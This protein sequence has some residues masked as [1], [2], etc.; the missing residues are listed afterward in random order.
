MK[1]VLAVCAITVT[2]TPFS[3]AFAPL[4]GGGQRRGDVVAMLQAAK[5]GIFYGTSTGSTETVAE[6][7]AAELE[8][9]AEGPFDVDALEGDIPDIIAKYDAIIAGTP[10]WNTG[11]DTERSG[12][13]WDEIYSTIQEVQI[14]GNK[15]A[16]IFGLGDQESY[17][18]CF[19]DAAGE[20]HDNFE[21]IGC[22]MF[23][24]TSQEGYEHEFSKSAR[25]DKFCG[26]ICDMVNQEELTEERV[27][28][29]VKQ[30][31]SEGFFGGEGSDDAITAGAAD[32]VI[33]ALEEL[34][35]DVVITNGAT[36]V[37]TPEPVTAASVS[38]EGFKR[39]YNPV[40]RSSMWTSPN[41]RKCFYT[42]DLDLDKAAARNF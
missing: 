17:G 33:A 37:A 14:N 8:G 32:S 40:T 5:V 38:S 19:A 13:G 21:R 10:T 29:W 35:E 23:G 15:K 20:L 16:A 24:Y 6:L 26:L 36:E 11:A 34:E 9:V 39:H 1:Y 18:H 42:A 30:L 27:E 3:A 28:A 41:G 7:I 22:Q 4:L 12:T 31:Q 25:G 2:A